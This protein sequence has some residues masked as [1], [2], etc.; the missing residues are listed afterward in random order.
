MRKFKIGDIVIGNDKATRTYRV[1]KKDWIG[2]VFNVDDYSYD[3]LG[4]DGKIY[5]DLNCDCFD[6]VR[7]FTKND[8]KNNDIVTLKNGDHL[9]YTNNL[10]YNISYNHDNGLNDIDDI[11]D[12]MRCDDADCSESDIIKVSR[13]IEYVDVFSRSE[14]KKM[15][16]SEICKEL[17]YDVEIIKEGE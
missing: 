11:R 15:T 7:S 12:D 17:G 6:F 1:T 13:P 9:I 14:P 8:L 2:I 4:Y 3:M 10:F 5:T 16:V